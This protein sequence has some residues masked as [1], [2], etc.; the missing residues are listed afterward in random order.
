MLPFSLRHGRTPS[1]TSL[2]H[3]SDTGRPTRA[4][5]RWAHSVP[6]VARVG[7]LAA[8]YFATAKFG[9]SLAVIH[10]NVSLVWPPTGIALA[11]LLLF[12][13]RLWPGIALGAF[14][15]NA[16]TGVGVLTAAGIGAGNTL[17]ALTG[18]YL[19]HRAARFRN[20]LERLQ[21]VLGLVALAAGLSTMVSATIGV[22]S[23][24]LGGAARWADYGSLWWQWWLGDAM[25][26]LVVAPVLLTWGTDPRIRWRAPRVAEAGVLLGLLGAVSGVVFGGQ[27]TAETTNFPPRAFAVFPLVIWAALRFGPREAATATLVVSGV[28]IWG[29][30]RYVGPLVGRTLTESLLVLQVFVSVVS[31]AALVL[32]AAL[33]QRRQGEEALRESEKRYRELFDNAIDMVYTHDLA[34][35]FTSLNRA[36]EKITGYTRDELLTM[37]FAQLAA[38]ADLELAR[39]MTS[40]STEERPVVHELEITAKDGRRVTLEVSTRLIS[41]G[42][43]PIGVQGIAR[44]ITE[45]KQDAVALEQANRKLSSWVNELEQRTRQITLLNEMGNVFLSC[46]SAEEAY[47]AVTQFAQK[48]LP[49]ESG[50][51]GVLN[52]SKNLV[53]IIAVWGESPPGERL[54]SPERC[55]ALR[56][57]RVHVVEVPGSEL[58]CQHVDPA[59]PGGYLCI[60]MMAQGE[61]LGVLHLQAGRSDSSRSDA[62]PEPLRES[63]QQLAVNMAEHIALALANLRLRETLRSQSL[64]DPLTGLFNRRYLEETLNRELRRAERSRRPIGIMML[65]IDDFKPLNDTL[66]HE[67][68]DALLRG[69]GLLLKAS[70]REG[71]IACRYGGDEFVLILPEARPELTRRRAEQL[72]EEVRH[73]RVSHRDRA[74]GPVT[75]S[76]GVAAFPD[77][78]TTAVTL[79][80][81][82]DA[83]LYRAKQ[84]GRDQVVVA[85]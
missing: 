53:E 22:A 44:D 8:V 74:I 19:L 66:G 64:E 27:L 43:E 41:Q 23:L 21:D 25:G 82:V 39:R 84:E 83:A 73:L 56:R 31:A 40:Q 47:T 9:L 51:L 42:G 67:A 58:R 7:V 60:P 68:G 57:G 70:V 29:A 33:A 72:R 24:C 61:P 6:Y 15:I 79:L 54:F 14:L 5:G 12:G 30:T 78:G 28:A 46:L 59:V 13:Y 71:D 1:C 37:N 36:G 2:G 45:R 63:Q 18:V 69:L 50:G 32:A 75:L 26:A 48:L 34:G 17:E 35:N 20:S 11:A 81:A 4:A 76:V 80:R 10:Q 16:S 55:W 85:K 38:P 65:D 77:H 49:A 62:A 52:P 3:S